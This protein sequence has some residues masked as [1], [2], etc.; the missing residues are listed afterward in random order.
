[1]DGEEKAPEDP[2]NAWNHLRVPGIPGAGVIGV[3]VGVIVGVGV[4]VGVTGIIVGEYV[5][6]GVNQNPVGVGVRGIKGYSFRF[7]ILIVPD[8]PAVNTH[9]L[10]VGPPSHWPDGSPP[11]TSAENPRS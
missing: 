10:N 4:T 1:M 7:I 8:C 5:G 9:G 2:D 11:L 6:V 3:S